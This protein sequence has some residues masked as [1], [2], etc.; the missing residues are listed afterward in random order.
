[1]RKTYMLLT[2]LILIMLVSQSTAQGN[3]PR[4]FSINYIQR[5]H[6][7]NYQKFAN[8]Q[9]QRLPK[10]KDNAKFHG[11]RLEGAIAKNLILGLYANGSLNDS[12]NDNGYT[13]WGGGIGVVTV[14]YR[15]LLPGNFF[16]GLGFGLGCGRFTYSSALWNGAESITSNSDAIFGE[17]S[18]KIGYVFKKKLI[19]TFDASYMFGIA[20]NEYNVGAK[21]MPDVF[22]KGWFI[23]VSIGSRLSFISGKK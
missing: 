22:P 1:M 23:S 20:S 6:F 5:L 17:P 10:L 8:I 13:S 9:D 14:E 18:L 11:M 2:F 7:V 3:E 21:S 15:Y 16:T 12:K 4:Y 19:L